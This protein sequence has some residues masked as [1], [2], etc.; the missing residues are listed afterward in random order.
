MHLFIPPYDMWRSGKWI[1]DHIFNK[2]FMSWCLPAGIL[3]CSLW[4]PYCLTMLV[5]DKLWKNNEINRIW[6]VWS[7]PKTGIF[8]SRSL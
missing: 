6:I 2:I 8:E 3:F 5:N 4:Y 1:P 7:G